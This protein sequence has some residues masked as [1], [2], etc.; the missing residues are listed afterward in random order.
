MHQRRYVFG[1]Y[2]IKWIIHYIIIHGTI[3]PSNLE[4]SITFIM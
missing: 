2:L 3:E 1:V 4:N